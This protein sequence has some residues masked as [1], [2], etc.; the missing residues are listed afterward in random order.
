MR[1]D[2][3]LNSRFL[4][5]INTCRTLYVFLPGG[6]FLPCGQGLDFDLICENSASIH[7]MKRAKHFQD[8]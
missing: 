2:F 3:S 8:F 1:S 6:V 7:S 5:R 4:F